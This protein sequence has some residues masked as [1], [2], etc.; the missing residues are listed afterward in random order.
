MPWGHAISS[1]VYATDYFNAILGDP[2]TP[3][4]HIWSLAI[5]EQFYVLWP[6]LFV[7]LIHKPK[8][9]AL[10]LAGLIG[11][12]WLWRIALTL[13]TA[14]GE[15]Y[16]YAAFD[17]RVDHILVGCLLAI[18]STLGPSSHLLMQLAR[19]TYFP[20]V[21]LVLL[22]V[23][24]FGGDWLSR[25][26]SRQA[27]YRD[28]IGFAIEPVIIA[29]FLIQVV[30]LGAR[31]PWNWLEWPPLRLIGRLSYSL[32]LYQQ[33]ALWS[34]SSRLADQPPVF[35]FVV[36][37]AVTALLAAASYCLVERPFLQIR[38]G[39]GWSLV[40]VGRRTAPTWSGAGGGDVPSPAA[41]E[42]SG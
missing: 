32:Y 17:T 11:T 26:T 8:Y 37:T 14:T 15:G 36:A 28:V 6:I 42:A 25:A 7:V 30:Q 27:E 31:A 40:R 13:F 21:T 39:A 1:L 12:V 2:N 3:F 22:V 24:V 33:L 38:N 16:I 20:V 29:V 9:L 5:E 10:T 35:R 34:V 41:R 23:S 18:L 4:S 19:K